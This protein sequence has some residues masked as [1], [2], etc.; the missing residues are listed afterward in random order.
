M[1]HRPG[2]SALH[3]GPDG[4]S[5][6][7]EGRDQLIL[8]KNSEW[9]DLRQRTRGICRAIDSGEADDDEAEGMTIERVE[10]ETPEKLKPLPYKEGLAVSLHS[11][12]RAKEEKY[13]APARGE[14]KRKATTEVVQTIS[15]PLSI[16]PSQ[17]SAGNVRPQMCVTCGCP[18]QPTFVICLGCGGHLCCGDC[19]MPHVERCPLLR[20]ARPARAHAPS[21]S[22]SS[23]LVYSL[24]AGR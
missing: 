15:A 6:H 10:R 24:V 5:R 7:P 9:S 1:I 19:L 20:A 3:K 16:A 8:A 21:S 22:L 2:Q 4:I 11:E 13:K 12:K 18:C 14:K 23:V 17:P